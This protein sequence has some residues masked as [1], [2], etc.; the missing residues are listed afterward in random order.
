MNII[1][2]P[3]FGEV[4]TEK[5]NGEFIFC[6]NDICEAL[7]LNQGTNRSLQNLDDD[8]KLTRKVY[9]SGQ[10]REMLF[11]TESG[12]YAL[13]IRSNK[14]E[15]RKFRKWITSEVLPSLR[16]YGIYSTDIRVMD[17][18]F[19]KSERAAI[20]NMLTAVDDSLSWTDKR[21][22]AKQC[23]TTEYTVSK[24]LKGDAQDAAMMSLLYARATGNKMLNK[25]FYTQEGAELLLQKLKSNHPMM[26]P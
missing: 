7:N 17:K 21:L 15:A 18:A 20:K 25:M 10:N 24:V 8:E 4:R 19:L 11:V 14:P 13:I 2:H 26:R 3:R 1:Q 23:L 9:A 6:A 16:K 12:L 22:V 5:H